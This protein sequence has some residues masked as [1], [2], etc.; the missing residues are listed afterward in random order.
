MP[1]STA[2]TQPGA[3]L[4]QPTRP[5][6]EQ[7]VALA[8]NPQAGGY[9]RR[10][11][12]GLRLALEVEGHRVRCV[13]S[14]DLDL[15][16][17]AVKIV[18]A[19]GGDGTAREAIGANAASARQAA[20]CVYPSGTINLIAREAG[21]RANPR[22]FARR[23]ATPTPRAHHHGTIAGHTFLCCASAGPDAEAVARVS[24][25]LKR[26]VGRLAYPLALLPLLWRWPRHRLRLTID[27]IAHEAEAVFVLKGRFYAGPW[28][29][30]P[31]A[32]LTSDAFRVLLL[33]RARRRDFARLALMALISPRLADPAWLRLAARK[34]C[35]DGPAGLPIQ[36]D[37][38]ILATTPA[39]IALADLPVTFL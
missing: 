7:C 21:Y 23:L 5:A 33:P 19:F 22:T 13:N 27:G 39:T 15:S 18:C 25:R 8:Y 1:T 12:E 24:P 16:D 29:L 35:I 32:A 10:R 36:A 4:P 38:D 11:L 9:S 34:V 20:W 37:G 30:D 26:R 17:D 6:P 14:L 31:M 28:T 2:P 3:P